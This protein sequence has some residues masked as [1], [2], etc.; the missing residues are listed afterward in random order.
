M[1]IYVNKN[2]YDDLIR[3][4]LNLLMDMM[5]SPQDLHITTVGAEAF[6]HKD[7]IQHY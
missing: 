4:S 1:N 3:I 5:T 7:Y 2:Y 6:G